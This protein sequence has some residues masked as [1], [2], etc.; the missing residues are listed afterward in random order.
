VFVASTSKILILV[1]MKLSKK[2]LVPPELALLYDFV[3]S[4]DL[5]HYTEKGVQHERHDELATARQLEEWMR[6]RGLLDS[7]AHLSAHG[8]RMA[9]KLRGT[10]RDYL[11][12][13][14]ENRSGEIQATAQL[15]QI[16]CA[17]PLVVAASEGRVTLEPAPG[18]SA[19]GRVLGELHVLATTARLDRLKMC[20]SEECHW[21]FYDR[22]KP[23]N[24]RWCSS[25][26]C[27][28]RHK[29]RSYRQRQLETT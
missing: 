13:A 16:S 28:N 18:S 23:G 21:V 29:T 26:V 25:A 3:N 9:V 5:R 1:S 19:L 20:S 15:N 10:L 11:Q 7:G 17:F 24:R 22:S 4:A 2:F 8:H 6:E 27:G 14:P 12:V